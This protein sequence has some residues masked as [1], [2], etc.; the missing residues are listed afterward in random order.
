MVRQGEALG[1]PLQLGAFLAMS[2]V[3]AACSAQQQERRDPFT[4]T[5]EL[6]A[7]SGGDAGA[8]RACITCHGLQGRGNGQATPWLAGLPEGY[9][10]KQ[11]QDYASGWRESEVM[12]PIAKALDQ[13][14]RLAVAA[15]YAGL[16]RQPPPAVGAVAS[17]QTSE[18]AA[19]Y[20]RGDPDRDLPA[21]ATCH[22]ENGEGV[23]PANPPLAGQPAGY[24]QAQLEL[25]KKSKRRNDPQ[26]Q[27]L[28]I[29]QSLSP[30][31]ISALAEYV[32][33]LGRETARAVPGP[34]A[35]P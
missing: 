3:L 34:A 15:Y 19:L 16:P 2:L 32:E 22:G 18:A 26:G 7:L 13:Q 20:H 24:T 23:G 1:S 9:L 33:A 6:I 17:R 35:S 10:Q 4:A 27:M 29:S 14:D 12:G 8:K 21:C 5:G 28:R 11:M 25:W 31:E 30:A